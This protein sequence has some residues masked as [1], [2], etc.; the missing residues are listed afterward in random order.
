MPKTNYNEAAFWEEKYKITCCEPYEWI[1]KP[2]DV[3]K[4]LSHHLDY[5]SMNKV[6]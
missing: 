1:C 5:S 3:F 2:E 6:L 4:E